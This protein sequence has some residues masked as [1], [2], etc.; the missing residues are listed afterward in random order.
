MNT[1]PLH[2]YNVGN[3][4]LGAYT[5]SV[6]PKN[7]ATVDPLNVKSTPGPQVLAL[8]CPLIRAIVTHSQ[9]SGTFNN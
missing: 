6:E 8:A 3:S 4:I 1:A 9:Q 2:N 7:D 5:N